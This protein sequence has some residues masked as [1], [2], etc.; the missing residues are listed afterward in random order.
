MVTALFVISGLVSIAGQL[1]ITEWFATRWGPTRS[2]VIGIGI[3]AAALIPTCSVA[4]RN[5]GGLDTAG[6]SADAAPHR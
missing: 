3:L 4:R 6:A 1:W 2:L 5:H